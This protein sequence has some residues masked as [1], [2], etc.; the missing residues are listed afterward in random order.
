MLCEGAA[1]FLLKDMTSAWPPH[2]F[3]HFHGY[4]SPPEVKVC[5]GLPVYVG[6][7]EGLFKAMLFNLGSCHSEATWRLLCRPVLEF[8]GND[9][10][11]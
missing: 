6:Q 1:F 3:Q 11:L 7:S 2:H 10:H 4:R 8:V 5:Q 9:L